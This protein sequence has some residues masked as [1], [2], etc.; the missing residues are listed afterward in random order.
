MP[1]I[2][3]KPHDTGS[4]MG[5]SLLPPPEREKGREK[6]TP[7]NKKE[8]AEK[9]MKFGSAGGRANVKKYGKEHMREIGKKGAEKRW[10]KRHVRTK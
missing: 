9:A 2:K 6:I 5:I 8:E 3:S 7:M 10:R 1:T 4:V